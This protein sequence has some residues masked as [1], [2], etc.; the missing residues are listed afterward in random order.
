MLCLKQNVA[1][2][3]KSFEDSV[4]DALIDIIKHRDVIFVNNQLISTLYEIDD[5]IDIAA[6]RYNEAVIQFNRSIRMTI[7]APDCLFF[8][9]SN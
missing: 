7:S 3:S 5:E 9:N 4:S 1:V 6:L 8:G 2:M